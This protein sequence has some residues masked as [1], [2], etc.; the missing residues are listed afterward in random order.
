MSNHEQHTPLSYDNEF[1]L[2][3]L[4]HEELLKV[5][6]SQEAQKLW[7]L[8]RS[9]FILEGHTAQEFVNLVF[10]TEDSLKSMRAQLEQLE[11][12]DE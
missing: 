12:L 7:A 1:M 8:Y 3:Y 11:S 6:K 5:G 2:V 10:D 9:K 4:Q